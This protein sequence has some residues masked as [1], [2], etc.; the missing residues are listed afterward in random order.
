MGSGISGGGIDWLTHAINH[1]SGNVARITLRLIDHEYQRAGEDWAGLDEPMKSFMETMIA[2][3][4]LASNL[5]QVVLAG[6]AG[7]LF[8]IDERWT[9]ETVLPLLDPKGNNDRAVRCWDGYLTTG[10]ASPKMLETSLLDLYIDMAQHFE[11]PDTEN[12]RLYYQHLAAIAL[13]SGINPVEQGWLNQF[14]AV[15]NVD[16]RA[17]WIQA[18][19]SCLS[20]MPDQSVDAQ[21]DVWMRTYWSNRLSSTPLDMTDPEA[22]SLANWAV[23]LKDRFP[24]AVELACRHKASIEG[25][26]M[27]VWTLRGRSHQPETTNHLIAHPEHVGRLLTHMLTCTKTLPPIA[28]STLQHD[29]SVVLPEL[30]DVLDDHQS[31]S[32][33]EQAVRLGIQTH[34]G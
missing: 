3:S 15:A 11:Q 25:H 20:D 18:V 23:Y 19:T 21:W 14:T 1:W 8:T 17:R 7:F 33:R 28:M 9:N 22:G 2:G 30:L 13:F 16:G 6:R 24:E 5:A 27:I 4:D 32:L 26:P 12:D 34:T 31:T 10:G 29:L